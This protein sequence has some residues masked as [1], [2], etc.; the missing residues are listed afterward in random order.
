MNGFGD[1]YLAQVHSD[2]Q[3]IVLENTVMLFCCEAL[4]MFCGPQNFT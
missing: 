4:E 1:R 3:R 2:M